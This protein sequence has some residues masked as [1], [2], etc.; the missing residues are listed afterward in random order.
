ML[1]SHLLL[2]LGWIGYFFIHSL[3]AYIPVKNW[4]RTKMG[5]SFKFYRLVYSIAAIGLLAPLLYWQAKIPSP[6]LW[7]KSWLT[8]I[9][10][11]LLTITGLWGMIICLKKYLVSPEGFKDLFFEGAKPA[12][13]VG[14][15]HRI[16]RHPL[17]L[18][19]FICLGGVLVFFPLVSNLIIYLLMI[20]Y[21]IV[22][23]PLEE[24]KLVALYGEAYLRYQKEV[25]SLI[26]GLRSEQ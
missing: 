16:V 4:F 13:Q 6:G 24:S 11:A 5:A 25:P 18:S 10:G 9:T 2:A 7:G 8:T 1:S 15:L 22:A 19:T 3:M 26:P 17:Y 21:V 14:G 23:I 20:A 12:L